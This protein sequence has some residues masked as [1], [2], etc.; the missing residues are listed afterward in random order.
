MEKIY[1]SQILKIKEGIERIFGGKEQAEKVI[2]DLLQSDKKM[3]SNDRKKIAHALFEITRWMLLWNGGDENEIHPWQIIK[4][5]LI[6]NNYNIPP[7]EEFDNIPEIEIRQIHV[8]FSIPKWIYQY[9]TEQLG[10]AW[11][12]LLTEMNK[13]ALPCLRLNQTFLNIKELESLIA[14]TSHTWKKLSETAF[15]IPKHIHL[16]KSDAF[17]KGAFEF[18]DF[19][20]Q[21]IGIFCDVKPG[22]LVMDLCAGAGGKSLQLADIMRNKGKIIAYD[23][24]SKKLFKLQ[25]RQKRNRFTNIHCVKDNRDLTNYM[26]K[27][28]LVLIDAPCSGIGVLKRNPD[29]KWKLTKEKMVELHKIQRQILI[30]YAEYCKPGGFL[31]YATCSIFPS[32]NEEQINFFQKSNSERFEFIESHS[33]LPSDEGDGFFMAK[34][35]RI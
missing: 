32:E 1:R 10:N 2:A 16:E 14:D 23:I 20:S 17:K 28:D 9:G 30:S 5:Y 7:F 27:A 12:T 24:D 6:A 8:K 35:R 18:Q 25:Q 33:L 26:G 15:Q 3:G 31:V 34:F 29:T 4:S 21:Q 13:E 19:H 22:M 11:E